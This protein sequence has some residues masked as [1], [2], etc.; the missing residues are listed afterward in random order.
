MDG[1]N[2]LKCKQMA[3]EEC[4]AGVKRLIREDSIRPNGLILVSDWSRQG[5][6]YIVYQV[7]CDHVK[8][9]LEKINCCRELWRIINCGGTFNTPSESRFAPIEVELLGITKALHKARYYIMGHSNL[10][11]VTEH[12]PLEKFLENEDVKEEEN[13]RLMNLRRKCENYNFFITY[14]SGA[15]NTADPLSRREAPAIGTRHSANIESGDKNKKVATI[16][17]IFATHNDGS[18][19]DFERETSNGPRRPERP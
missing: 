11:I 6:G 4:K 2:Y 17:R 19:S 18:Q 5:T 7:L 14:K 1:I 12:K 15:L 3:V 16:L 10:H 8:P 9:K 13:R